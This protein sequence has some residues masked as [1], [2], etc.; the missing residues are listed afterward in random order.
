MYS[1]STSDPVPL[2]VCLPVCPSALQSVPYLIVPLSKGPSSPP[3]R[4]SQ[5]YLDIWPFKRF[6]GG[7]RGGGAKGKGLQVLHYIPLLS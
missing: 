7:G 5:H 3:P 2:S 1:P 4:Q 6:L